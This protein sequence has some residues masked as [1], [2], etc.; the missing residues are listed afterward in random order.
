MFESTDI[1]Q[2]NSL[3]MR[4][5]NVVVKNPEHLLNL[6]IREFAEE[7]HV[8]TS[9]IIHM[10]KKLG[11]DGWAELKYYLKAQTL[12]LTRETQYYDNML[13][14]SMFLN[15][16]NSS[17]YQKNL[18]MA[19]EMVAQA[20]YSIFC[21]VG[22]SGSLSDYGS[23][24]FVNIGLRAFAISDPFQAIQANK[25]ADIVAL[26]LSE[27]GNTEQVVNKAIEFKNSGAKIISITNHENNNIAKLADIRLTYNL[28]EEWSKYYPLG[29]LTTQL[30]VLAL[31]EILAHR[32][33]H[34][35]V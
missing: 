25:S 31:I 29:N 12:V 8:S 33:L 28:L 4:A 7:P 6:T 10:C 23:K 14:F 17:A 30:P 5:F 20:D 26:I 32:A 9:T 1:R 3:E 2:L 35:H 11:F 16:L 18:E 24:Y 21:G 15:R 34:F 13:E 19:A 27:S 22:T